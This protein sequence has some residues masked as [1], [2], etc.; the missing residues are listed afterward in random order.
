MLCSYLKPLIIT[1]G[2]ELNQINHE[3]VTLIWDS[4]ET[5]QTLEKATAT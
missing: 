1:I 2:S 4:N 5:S 3:K